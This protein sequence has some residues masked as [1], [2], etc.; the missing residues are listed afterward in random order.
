M[1]QQEFLDTSFHAGM[2]VKH[3]KYG[4]TYDVESVDFEEC[5]IGVPAS[6]LF[7]DGDENDT[8]WFRCE[9]CIIVDD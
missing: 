9:N 1:T 7:E 4:K 3:L 2:K 6:Q 8:Q 5:L